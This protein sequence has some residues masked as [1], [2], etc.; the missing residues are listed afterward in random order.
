MNSESAVSVFFSRPFLKIWFYTDEPTPSSACCQNSID[1]PRHGLYKTPEG[2]LWW[3]SHELNL[4]VQHIPQM[5]NWIKIWGI[6]KPG[7][8]LE[9][10]IMFL[11]PSLNNVCNCRVYYSA[12]RSLCHPETTLSWSGVLGLQLSH[13]ASWCHPFPQ[14]NKAHVH[15]CQ[16]DIKENSPDNLFPQVKSYSSDTA[17]DCKRFWQWTIGIPPI[18]I[19]HIFCDLSHS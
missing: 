5:L 6:W 1:P 8:H 7:Q 15:G 11:K 2:A 12:E 18:T 13:S 10:F 4:L 14:D 17:H 3:S 9:L 16:C 19:I